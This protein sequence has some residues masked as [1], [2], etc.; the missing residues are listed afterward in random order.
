MMSCPIKII[1]TGRFI[2]CVGGKF[3]VHRIEPHECPEC[4]RITD[5]FACEYNGRK[6]AE[7]MAQLASKE[8]YRC[9][10]CIFAEASKG[11]K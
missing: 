1:P 11:V 2:D 10:L 7:F 5:E 4:G 9:S 3:E 8:G 6:A